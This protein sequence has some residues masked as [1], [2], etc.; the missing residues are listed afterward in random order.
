MIEVGLDCSQ[1][2]LTWDELK[3]RVLYAESSGFDGAWVFDHFKALYGDPSGPCLEGWT[4]L[5]ALAAVTETIRLGPLVTGVTY[6]HPSILATEIVTADH[7]SHGRIELAIGAA[8][9]EEEHV[10][11]G[12]DF[13]PTPERVKRLEEAITIM[14]LL[15]TEDGASFDGDHYRLKAASFNPKPVQQPHPPVWVGAAGEKL[16]LPLVARQADVWHGMGSPQDLVRKS[17]ILDEHAEKAGRDPA[18]IRRATSLSLS[19]P[20]DEV[21]SKAEELKKAG[22]TYLTA[23]WPSE[24]RQRVDEFV[25]DVMPEIKAE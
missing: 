4:L 1:H 2:Q 5:A 10:E 19:E 21:R 7:I 23:D 6:R 14:K 22:F 16:M 8:W 12:I 15:M 24:G 25:S 18:A 20:W 17:R 11:L 3:E 13:P 9:N